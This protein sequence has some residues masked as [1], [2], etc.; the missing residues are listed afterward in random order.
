M[1]ELKIELM[2]G[3]NA[4]KNVYFR[5]GQG[6]IFTYRNTK[7]PILVSSIFVTLTATFY[8]AALSYPD[9]GWMLA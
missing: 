9:T 6:S 2:D 7:I 1:N 3:Y 8:F 5:N 4:L